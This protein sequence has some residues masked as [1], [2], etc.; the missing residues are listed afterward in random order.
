[1]IRCER[2]WA[3]LALA[4]LIGG[5][6]ASVGAV[7]AGTDADA[8][9]GAGTGTFSIP[10]ATDSGGHPLDGSGGRYTLTF[11]KGRL[12][13]VKAS[14]SLTMY[15]LPDQLLVANPIGRYVINS[16]MLADLER[17]ANGGLTLYLQR[18]PPG[19]EKD[20][21]WLPA[22]DGPFLM[23]LRLHRPEQSVLDNAW[24]APAVVRV[25]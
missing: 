12:P 25:E 5:W 11:A 18:E 20:S 23:I 6:A 16:P 14:W 17:D 2:L 22:P 8:T 7:A 10:F 4:M 24:E 15:S 19:E 1:M 13:P 21:N 3:K 9:A